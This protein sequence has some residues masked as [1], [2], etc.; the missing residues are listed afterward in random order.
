VEGLMCDSPLYAPYIVQA[1]RTYYGEQVINP[2]DFF[3][4][5]WLATFDRDVTKCIDEV[6]RYY[7]NTYEAMYT[8]RFRDALRNDQLAVEFPE[9]KALLDLNNVGRE[10]NPSTPAIILHGDA[11]PIVQ[12]R[13]VEPFVARLCEANKHVTYRVYPGVHHFL[14]RQY[15]HVDTLTWM[16][17]ILT[18]NRPLSDCE[19]LGPP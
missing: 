18:G 1:Y 9:F 10:V 4:E 17:A 12:L 13:T 19:K 7:P 11:D 16:E 8:P 15:S 2:Q 3:Q 14:T 5:R 6:L